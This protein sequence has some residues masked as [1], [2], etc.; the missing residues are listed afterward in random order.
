[1]TKLIIIG[2]THSYH[3][4]IKVPDGDIFIHTGDFSAHGQV[5]DTV[6]FLSWFARQPH[7][8]KVLVAGNH[9]W[10]A[11]KDP[12]LFRSLLDPS[13]TY[14]EDSG[15]TVGGLR[16]W[17]SPYQP[18]F[19]DWAFNCDRGASIRAHWDLIPPDL[20][21][22]VTHGPPTL[23]MLDFT[24]HGNVHVGDQ[25]LYDAIVRA[26]PKLFACSHIHQGHGHAAIEHAN[27]RTTECYNA[28]I[29]T[30]A[31]KPTNAPWVID[32]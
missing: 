9:D 27:G 14:L 6:A 17:G 16:F 12:A 20:D 29:C 30:E 2:C 3:N 32:L 1:M 19:L 25:D 22:L 13:I 18:R 10:L 28:S 11:E 21:V 5:I 7:A 8:H 26:Q 31:Y 15:A 24:P 23:G 4:R